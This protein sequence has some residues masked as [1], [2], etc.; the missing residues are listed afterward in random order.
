LPEDKA[1]N[2][3]LKQEH[4]NPKLRERISEVPALTKFEVRA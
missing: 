2:A 1:G 4:L 3:R